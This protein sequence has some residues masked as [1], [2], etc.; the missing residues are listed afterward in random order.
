MLC[1]PSGLV[2]LWGCFELMG[3]RP[4]LGLWRLLLAVGPPRPLQ[5]Q[6][7]RR[8]VGEAPH[9]LRVPSCA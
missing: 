4:L 7:G 3:V 2:L 6:A 8:A 5:G 9:P 1:G